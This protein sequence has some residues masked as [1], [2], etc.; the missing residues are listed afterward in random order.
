MKTHRIDIN[1]INPNAYKP[2]LSLYNDLKKST[3]TN[4]EFSLIQIRASQINGC[5]YCIQ[6]HIKEAIEN[7]E[8]QFRIHALPSWKESPFFTEEEQVILEMT[9]QITHISV[10]GL[11]DE[12]YE[13]ALSLFGEKKVADI[14]MGIC[15]INVWNRI[16]R[17][18]LLVPVPSQN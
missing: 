4:S 3:L 10:H 7:E 8:K 1:E 17:A 14:I 9:E 12:L 2:V 5:A 11:S 6:S 15:C 13:Q 16:G 18:T